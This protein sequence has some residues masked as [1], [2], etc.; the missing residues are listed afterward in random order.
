MLRGP[1]FINLLSEVGRSLSELAVASVLNIACVSGDIGLIHRKPSTDHEAPAKNEDVQF[2]KGGE[3]LPSRI[4][5]KLRLGGASPP[6]A[7]HR[8]HSSGYLE[9]LKISCSCDACDACVA[10]PVS[11][12]GRRRRRRGY[13]ASSIFR[14]LSRSAPA[15]RCEIARTS[16]HL[17]SQREIRQRRG[18]PPGNSDR[19]IR[20]TRNGANTYRQ[21]RR[22][23]PSTSAEQEHGSHHPSANSR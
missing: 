2:R 19:T 10:F 7:T 17:N 1:R 21:R 11:E 15:Q 18:G 9:L 12:S 20:I 8:F 22:L 14:S 13:S 3:L 5:R 6:Y 16:P 23:G 4:A